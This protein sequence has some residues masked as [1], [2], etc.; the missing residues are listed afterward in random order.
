MQAG[1]IVRMAVGRR[2]VP[3]VGHLEEWF[4]RHKMPTGFLR[5]LAD[6]QAEPLVLGHMRPAG[7]LRD[8][9]LGRLGRIKDRHEKAGRSLP[10]AAEIESAQAHPG[11][12][13]SGSAP[14]VP[15]PAT[16]HLCPHGPTPDDFADTLARAWNVESLA[17]ALALTAHLSQRFLLDDS[18]LAKV[19]EAL[20]SI[21]EQAGDEDL[22][23]VAN[24]LHAASIVAA[25]ARDTGLADSI[26]EVVSRLIGRVSRTEELTSIIRVLFQAAAGHAEES[27]WAKWLATPSGRSRGAVSHGCERVQTMA[28]V[29]AGVDGHGSADPRLG[30]P[31][32]EAD[33]GR[34]AGS[35]TI[36]DI[37]C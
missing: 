19:R 27:E 30:S 34:C 17:V 22:D 33:S 37:W 7:T 11:W 25:A 23:S 35:G 15:G 9:V 20:A 32:S 24:H 2:T 4:H 29:L 16:M 1:L 14:V 12:N 36:G 6:C 3:E 21:A 26:G 18:Q 10:M 5:R 31:P 8:E 28:M 13:W